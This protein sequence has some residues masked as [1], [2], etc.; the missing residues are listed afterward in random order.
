MT[1][2]DVL[3]EKISLQEKK[4]AQIIAG[5]HPNRGTICNEENIYLQDLCGAFFLLKHQ[6]SPVKKTWH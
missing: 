2:L 4:I 1:N 5:N 3:R 6:G